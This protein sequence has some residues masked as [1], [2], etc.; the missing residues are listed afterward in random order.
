[1][2]PNICMNCAQPIELS[3]TGFPEKP[4]LWVH[5]DGGFAGC[6]HAYATPRDIGEIDV[7]ETIGQET[8]VEGPPVAVLCGSTRFRASIEAANHEL[9]LQG[10]IVLAPGVF[11]HLLP[12]GVEIDDDDKAAL[13]RL[14]LRKID[15]ADVVMVVNDGG[16]IGKSTETEIAYAKSLDK[17]VLYSVPPADAEDEA[18]AQR[19]DF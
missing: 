14:H 4:Q 10:Y 5:T 16:Y 19:W 2:E 12:E 7:R 3:E 6:L 9:T 11:H 13:D 1:M 17:P 8:A 18:P 15:L